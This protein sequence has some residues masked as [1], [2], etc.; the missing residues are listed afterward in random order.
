MWR[1]REALCRPGQWAGWGGGFSAFGF[2]GRGWRG[3]SELAGI[4]KIGF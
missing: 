3:N 2:G 1:Q 4:A